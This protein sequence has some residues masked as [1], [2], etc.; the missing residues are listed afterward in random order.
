MDKRS[1]VLRRELDE[2]LACLQ[3]TLRD[4]EYD[5]LLLPN[6]IASRTWDIKNLLLK[7]PK[8]CRRREIRR[9]DDAYIQHL[10]M[11]IYTIYNGRT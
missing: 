10:M 5:S 7:A 9:F 11:M 4:A 8:E 1:E 3:D 2:H 6:E